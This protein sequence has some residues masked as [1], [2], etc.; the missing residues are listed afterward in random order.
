MLK[1]E[2]LSLLSDCLPDLLF[3]TYDEETNTF[4]CN[5][6]Y[7]ARLK[8][9]NLYSLERRRERYLIIYLT[10]IINGLVPNPGNR[11]KWDYDV[12]RKCRISVVECSP[13][14]PAWVRRMRQNSI[15]GIG[16]QIFNLLPKDLRELLPHGAPSKIIANFKEKLDKFLNT[17][18]DRPGLTTNGLNNSLLHQIPLQKKRI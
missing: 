15:F 11:L 13:E 8:F 2:E 16:V 5:T 4:I 3:Q 10:K 1:S 6:S 7:E 9:L 14:T 12:R 18:E 17:I